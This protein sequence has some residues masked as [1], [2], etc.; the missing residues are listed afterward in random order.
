MPT[1]NPPSIWPRLTEAQR[2]QVIAILVQML[3]RQL[4]ER[5][6]AESSC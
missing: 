2:A 6:E 5:Q 3:L 1:L 4:M